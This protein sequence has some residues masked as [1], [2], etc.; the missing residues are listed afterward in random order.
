MKRVVD[1]LCFNS[2]IFDDYVIDEDG[3]WAYLCLEHVLRLDIEDAIRVEI[4][5]VACGV[6]NCHRQAVYYLDIK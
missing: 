4:E 5:D 3:T 2:W 6:A 1:C